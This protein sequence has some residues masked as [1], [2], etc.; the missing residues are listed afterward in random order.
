MWL[1]GKKKKKS[2]D[3]EWAEIISYGINNA[4]DEEAKRYYEALADKQYQADLAAFYDL[5]AEIKE[6]YTVINNV[7]SFSGEAGNKLIERCVEA[8][9]LDNSIKP[10][11]DYYDSNKYEYCEPYKI[12]AMVYEKREE[13]HKAA[14]VCV[15]SIHQGYTRDGTS[16]GMRGRLARMIR[17]GNLPLTDD[18]KAILNL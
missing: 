14:T 17:K 3:E 13:Y 10:K 2:D 8:I 7:S 9:N 5:I 12:L 18:Y 6:T 15:F 1:F 11:R 16:G 4:Q